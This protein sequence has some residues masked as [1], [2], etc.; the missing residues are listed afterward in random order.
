M[1]RTTGSRGTGSVPGV[2]GANGVGIYDRDYFRQE[3]SGFFLTAP[4]TAIATLII[5]NVVVYLAEILLGSPIPHQNSVINL[6]SV[7]VTAPHAGTAWW[8]ANTLTHPWLWWQF[9]TYGFVHA[10]TMEHILFNMLALGFLGRDIEAWYGTKEFVR[11]YFAILV[12]GSVVWAIVNNFLPGGAPAILFGASGAVTGVVLLYALNFPRRILYLMFVL[13]VPAW[14][15]GVLVVGYDVWGA[16]GR[17]E[18]GVAYSVHLAGAAFAFIYFHQR[19]NLGR[20]LQGRFRLPRLSRPSLRLHQPEDDFDEGVPEEE[21]DR[22][23]EKIHTQGE[24]SLTRKE[25]QILE[26]ASR[27]YQKRRGN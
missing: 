12:F 15:V 26:N 8:D 21:V 25:R 10:L 22:I 1:K 6:L 7:H 4:R 23:L 14:L 13:P 11:L 27:E 3:R 9:I 20:L 2:R 18:A 19:W 5:V 17:A 16:M 24:S